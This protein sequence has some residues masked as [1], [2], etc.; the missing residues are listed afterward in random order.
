M[1]RPR[2]DVRVGVVLFVALSLLA[3]PAVAWAQDGGTLDTGD[4]AWMLVSCALVML[5]TPGLALFYGG[6]VRPKNV[7][8]TMM[9][10]LI[11][12]GVMTL[13]WVVV[14]YSISF[15]P[16]IGGFFGNPITHLFF[17]DVGL[18]LGQGDSIPPMIFAM[19]QGMFAIITPALISGAIAERMKFRAYILFIL[20]WGTLVYDPI[21]HWVWGEGGWLFEKGALDFAGGTVVHISSGVSALVAAIIIG[22]RLGY[23]GAAMPPHNLVVSAIGAGLL[24]FGWFGFNAGSALASNQSAVLAF[25]TT[26]IAAA[27]GA[28]FWALAETMHRGKASALGV[29]SGIVAGLVG[30]TPAAGFVGP[31]AAIGIGAAAGVICYGAVVFKSS[32]GYDDS[33]DAFGVHGIGGTVGALLTGVFARKVWGGTD[34]L[35]AGNAGQFMTQV[36][37]VVATW[38]YAIVMTLIILQVVR[39]LAGGLRVNPEDETGGLDLADHG[40]TAYNG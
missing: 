24:W 39:V 33:L 2:A 18:E 11:A 9:M 14:G 15:G 8:N 16:D 19:F 7:L 37:A 36:I 10:S 29:V 35:L 40:E 17:K 4:T 34:G 3:L 20:L 32:R 12:L 27:S 13:Q 28:T 25:T 38:A 23:P 6:L 21:C 22:P 31:V 26:H 1:F 30:I 5:M